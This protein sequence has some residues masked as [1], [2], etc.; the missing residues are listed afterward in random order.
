MLCPLQSTSGFGKTKLLNYW[1]YST[2]GVGFMLSPDE[3]KEKKMKDSTA[4]ISNTRKTVTLG[5]L[6]A[7]S[8]VLVLIVHFPVFPAVAFLEYD[9]ADV[10]III[11]TFAFGPLGGFILTAVVSIL[12]GVTVSS[13]S[14]I[15]G[16]I[17]HIF[18]TG[19]YCLVGGNLYKRNKT[20][21]GAVIALILGTVAS[22]ITMTLWNIVV[23]PRFLGIPIVAIIELMPWIV[24]FNI[25]KSSVNSIIAY[26]VYK[27]ISNLIKK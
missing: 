12:Q 17:M 18:S 7:I 13:S 16:I 9:P 15:V 21:K 1:N 5:L 4:K 2:D 14:G 22:V 27:P 10:P 26:F 11:G 25:I 19:S 24:L 3:R 23:T 8:I 6:G 20:K